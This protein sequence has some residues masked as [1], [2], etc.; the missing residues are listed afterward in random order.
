VMILGTTVGRPSGLNSLMPVLSN[1]TR[2]GVSPTR[3]DQLD[4][5]LRCHNGAGVVR[6][7]DV[8]RGVHHLVRVVRRRIFHDCDVVAELGGIADGRLQAGVRNEPNHDEPMDSMLLELQIQVSVGEAAGT[9][10]SEATISPGWGA[11][12]AR[13]SPPQVPYSKAFRCHAAF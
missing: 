5:F 6:D 2:F 10:C 12:S 11:N 13:N 1:L 4:D 7:V 9:Q 8:E 3:S